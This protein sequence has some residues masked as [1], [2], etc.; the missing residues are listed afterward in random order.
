MAIFYSLTIHVKY[1]YTYLLTYYVDTY[2]YIGAIAGAGGM[3]VGTLRT[4][5]WMDFMEAA[6]IHPL[7]GFLFAADLH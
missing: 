2:P 1:S 5:P 6:K 4:E 7:E 3:Y